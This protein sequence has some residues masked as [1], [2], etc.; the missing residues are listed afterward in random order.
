MRLALVALF[1]LFAP[2]AFADVLTLVGKLGDRD[3]QVELT[4]PVH[5]AVAGRYTFSDTGGDIPLVPVSHANNLWVL[6]E[7]AIC[8]DDDCLLGDSGEVLEAPIAAV[9]ELRYDPKTYLARGTRT[10]EGSKSKRQPLDL[11]VMAWR[12]FG[13]SETPT[14]AG[15][16]D[17]SAIFGY[18]PDMP[19]DWSTAPYEM[20]LLDVPLE[21]GPAQA[22]GSASVHA[23]TDP[24]T[25]FAFPRVLSFDDGSPVEPANAILADAHFRMSL[26]ALDCLALQY[27]SY[28]VNSTYS[29]RGGF[30]GDYD[31][32]QVELS[33]A[34]PQVL[35]WT[36]SGSL[37]CTGAHPYNHID[38]YSYDLKTGQRLDLGRL[39]T[40]WV[41]REWGAAP[42][43][44]VDRET[45]AQA[46][47]NYSWGP[48]P[49]LIAYVRDNFPPGLL[50][51]DA[52]IDEAC[53]SDQALA[54]QL[55]IRLAPGPSV[56]FTA[57]GFPHVISMCNGDLFTKPLA[58]VAHLLTPEAANYLPELRK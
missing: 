3:I 49:D 25:R 35:S 42:D 17:R 15:L 44:I 8:G 1:S 18:R 46:P 32:E 40:D 12:S 37:W 43:E 50:Y 58:E 26:S 24:R 2:P 56:V 19:L 33:Y 22:L 4:Q 51:D 5:G 29:I 34:S 6:H 20:N 16:H 30:L 14:A 52:E 28:G 36:E 45:V 38:S 23:V 54:D 11:M 57:N 48:G 41:P 13:E 39:F 9:W 31:S 53:Y 55:D 7:E 47:D 27:A 21:A 10:A